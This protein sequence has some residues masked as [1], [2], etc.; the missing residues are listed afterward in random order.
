MKTLSATLLSLMVTCTQALASA[1]GTGSEGIGLLG[2]FFI[3]FGVLV[4]LFQFLPG[5]AL[6]IGIVKGVFAPSEA[7]KTST[8]H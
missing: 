3:A 1:E 4:I 6:F 8:K 7:K 5:L 2:T